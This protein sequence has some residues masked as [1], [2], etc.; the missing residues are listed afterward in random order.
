MSMLK[1]WIERR[2]LAHMARLRKI[3]EE[4]LFPSF[5]EAAGDDAETYE[6]MVRIHKDQDHAWGAEEAKGE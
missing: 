4:I 1:R 6:R 5:K 2:V 3:D